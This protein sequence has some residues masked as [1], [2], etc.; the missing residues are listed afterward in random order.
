M[1][2]RKEATGVASS[3]TIA[4]GFVLMMGA[5]DSYAAGCDATLTSERISLEVAGSEL[6]VTG[7][8]TFSRN[9]CREELPMF[10]PIVDVAP[11]GIPHIV[12][13]TL[14]DST[15]RE[16]RLMWARA[17]GGIQ[18]TLPFRESNVS[19]VKIV[20]HQT[21][22]SRRAEY[23]LTTARGWPQALQSARIEVRLPKGVPIVSASYPLT[24]ITIRGRI[25]YVA[26]M[27]G[28]DPDRDLIIEW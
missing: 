15:G 11:L 23:V 27:A 20:Y 10:F 4:A 17:K 25:V 16:R 18:W 26:E 21:L 19:E 8:Y 5:F 28:F 3:L 12:S 7:Q 13:A 24:P 22:S 9:G 14:R 1:P 2:T 6:T